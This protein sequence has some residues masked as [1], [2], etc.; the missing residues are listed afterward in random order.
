MQKKSSFQRRAFTLIELLTVIAIIGI[1]A[2]VLLPALQ[3][4]KTA[5]NR[6]ASETTFR[7]WATGIS[8]Y[9]AEYKYYPN[10]GTGTTG[11][12]DSY[13][14]LSSSETAQNLVRALQGRN[15]DGTELS[16]SEKKEYNRRGRE[17]CTF[18]NE[19]FENGDPKTKK[20]TD[21]FGNTHIRIVLDTDNDGSVILREL[22]TKTA[23]LGLQPGNK[24]NAKIVI[25][26]L[27]RDGSGFED[28]IVRQ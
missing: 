10:L 7:Q 4:G 6:A 8:A 20:L 16:D 18:P 2:V 27:Q 24:L 25:Y 13:Y 12:S 11:T 5:A 14:D 28:I 1:L 9:K 22:P 17:F 21:R 26:T 19:C 3:G 23:D 15:M